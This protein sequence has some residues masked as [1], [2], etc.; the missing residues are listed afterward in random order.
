MHVI[1]R[2]THGV[3]DYTAGLVLILSPRILGL[4]SGSPEANVP[5]ALGWATIA[6][7]LVTRYELGLFKLLP[8]RMHLVLDALNGF[9][10]ALSPWLFEFSAR[11]WVPH[12]IL[13]LLELTV[14][15][16]TRSTP[17]EHGPITGTPAHH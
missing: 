11:V 5:V 8:F 13:G 15:L 1:S 10:L 9:V 2:R 3:L 7:S 4:D 6:D 17:A 16:T 12:A 14:V